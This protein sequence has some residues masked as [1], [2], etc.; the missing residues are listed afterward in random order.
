[1][2]LPGGATAKG[3][4]KPK[5]PVYSLHGGFVNEEVHHTECNDGGGA[6]VTETNV[7]WKNVF[8]GD[9]QRGLKLT[10]T[11]RDKGIV[12][13]ANQFVPSGTEESPWRTDVTALGSGTL[14][15]RRD[16]TGTVRVSPIGFDDLTQSFK[17]VKKVGDAA[18]VKINLSV[19]TPSADD[20][21]CYGQYADYSAKGSL[22][23]K[24]VQ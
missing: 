9:T 2:A 10:K 11:W 24:R 17:G 5:P 20:H 13:S 7:T 18:V 19:H 1:V 23:V 8:S 16:G 6:I 22:L 15:V 12:D 21:M 4:K 14:K 3:K